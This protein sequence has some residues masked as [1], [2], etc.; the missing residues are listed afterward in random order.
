MLA[1]TLDPGMD[2]GI[3]RVVRAI[4]K[5]LRRAF[6]IV[7]A[8]CFGWRVTNG[9]LDGPHDEGVAT[10]RGPGRARGQVVL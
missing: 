9:I 2:P 7:G 4:Y 5:Q 10:S 6:K 1:L 8:L 3:C